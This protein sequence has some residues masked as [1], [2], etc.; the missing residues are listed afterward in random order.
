M[1]L[2]RLSERGF[3]LNELMLTVAV[4]GAIMAIAV[5]MLGDVTQSAKLSAASREVERELQSARLKAVTTNRTLRVRLNC[6][7]TGYY[8]TVEYL[9]TAADS[10]SNRCQ[11]SAYPFPADADLM[12]RPNYDG[13]VRTLPDKTTV[14]NG[15]LQ[16]QPDGTAFHV[17]SNVVTD[18]TDPVTV[19]V[20]RDGKS[21]AITI[22]A[23][24]KIQIHQ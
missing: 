23:A 15:I 9:G 21:K 10:A 3:S 14:S 18:I 20:T 2:S 8:R 16:F 6:P 13:P 12:T 24:G 1:G 11:Q 19:T 4:A 7:T 22:N 5:P 17:V